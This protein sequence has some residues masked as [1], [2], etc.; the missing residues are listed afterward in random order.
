MAVITQ[1]DLRA[2]LNGLADLEPDEIAEKV[3]HLIGKEKAVCGHPQQCAIALY[4]EKSIGVQ[5]PWQV[6]VGS[7]TAELFNYDDSES[8]H[9]DLPAAVEDF[10][11]KFD[12]G[13]YPELTEPESLA[14]V[15]RRVVASPTG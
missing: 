4:L 15:L 13:G 12:K 3:K 2:A 11:H 7:Y 8:F 5:R 9:L 1:A 10:I 6:H 14:K